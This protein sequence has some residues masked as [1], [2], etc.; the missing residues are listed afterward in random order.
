MQATENRLWDYRILEKIG[1]G[2]YGIVYKVRHKHTDEVYALKKINITNL[3]EKEKIQAFKEV[4]LLRKL[5]HKHI[6]RYFESFLSADNLYIVMEYAEKGD[7]ATAMQ[8]KRN[9]NQKYR[10]VELWALF[11]ILCSAVKH[12]HDNQIIHRDIKL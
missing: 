12:L 2:E 6:I 3:T 10:E 5:D 8:H 11:R 1:Q 9:L 4:K 7:L